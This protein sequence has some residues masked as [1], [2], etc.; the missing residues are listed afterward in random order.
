MGKRLI[1]LG[2]AIAFKGVFA[3][4]TLGIALRAW[5]ALPLGL[6]QL[7]AALLQRCFA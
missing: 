4:L 3:A 5:P 2:T 6:G 1:D 7:S